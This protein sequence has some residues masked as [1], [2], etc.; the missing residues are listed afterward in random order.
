MKPQDHRKLIEPDPAAWQEAEITRTERAPDNTWNAILVMGHLDFWITKYRVE[1][2][3]V[4][5]KFQARRCAIA[6]AD[7][8]AYL[9]GLSERIAG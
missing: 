8:L 6:D 1:D 9:D 3:T 2:G 5:F 7:F 4:R